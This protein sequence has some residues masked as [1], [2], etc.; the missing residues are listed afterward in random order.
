MNKFKHGDLVQIKWTGR[1]GRIYN[2]NNYI[3]C[4]YLISLPNDFWTSQSE[5]DLN[6][7]HDKHKILEEIID[8]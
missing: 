8:E 1:V 4:V 2:P 5:E 7:Y 3:Q 6:Y